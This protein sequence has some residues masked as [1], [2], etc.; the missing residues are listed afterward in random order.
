MIR[1]RGRFGGW[2]EDSVNSWIYDPATTVKKLIAGTPCE[3]TEAQIIQL[4]ETGNRGGIALMCRLPDKARK[5]MFRKIRRAH[6]EWNEQEVGIE[7][8][9][10]SCG[11][12]LAHR[13]RAYFEAQRDAPRPELDV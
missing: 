6:P 10:R 12:D 11:E 5:R 1:N 3:H 2:Q 7:F 9:A 13:L 8:V 4:R